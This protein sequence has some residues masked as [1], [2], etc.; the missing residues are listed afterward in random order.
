MTPRIL[1]ADDEPA[2]LKVMT[3][4]LL[5]LDYSVDA[6]STGVEAWQRF[7]AASGGYALFVADATLQDSTGVA[8]LERMFAVNPA[9][10]FLICSG[11]PY[12]LEVLPPVIRERT[13]FL[14]KP[15][16]PTMLAE[17]VSELVAGP[18]QNP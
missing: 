18:R 16:T 15:F 7:E 2:L 9:I 6:C 8:L 11:Y 1:I 3:Q 13:R 4:Y 17:T 5:R 10:S 14:Q 12:D